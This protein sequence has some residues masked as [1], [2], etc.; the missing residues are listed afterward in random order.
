MAHTPLTR[1]R[2]AVSVLF[3]VNGFAL[4]SWLPRLAEL[5]GDLGLNDAQLGLVLAAGAA[6]GL[7]VGPLGG[8]LVAH[9]SSARVSVWALVLIVPALPL[10]GSPRTAS[11][12]ALSCC[13]SAR[14]TR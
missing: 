2:V 4:S 9:S 14:S 8:Y 13:G 1:A 11:C 7:V 5:Q 10:S 12:W 6:G 3:V